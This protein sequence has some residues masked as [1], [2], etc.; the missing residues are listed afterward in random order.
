[1]LRSSPRAARCALAAACAALLGL[2][3]VA[4]PST[5]PQAP[6]PRAAA[7]LP[8]V[9]RT[10]IDLAELTQAT[11]RQSLD[12]NRTAMVWWLPEQFWDEALRSQN[13]PD[14][15]ITAMRDVVRPYVVVFALDVAMSADGTKLEG[16]SEQ[17]LRASIQL[18]DAQ[19][20]PYPPL[21]W[22]E[23]SPRMT[24]LLGSMQPQLASMM[25]KVGESFRAY[26]FPAKDAEGK[27][28]ADPL[29]TGRFSVDIGDVP[30]V[31]ELPLPALIAPRTCP[32]DSAQFTGTF[33]FCPFHGVEL[34][35]P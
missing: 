32:I 27:T 20:R 31:F 16:R 12:R 25:G 17:A 21:P 24:A 7:P 5:K 14:A 22:A 34:V 11:R 10:Q 8:L 35:N 19:G 26:V 33:R 30:L 6:T 1:M 15:M 18:R 28:I 29:A 9:P 23:V 2:G 3:C 13:S 4:P